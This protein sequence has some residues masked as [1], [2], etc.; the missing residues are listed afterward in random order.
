MPRRFNCN[1]IFRIQHFKEINMKWLRLFLIIFFFSSMSIA[2]K[3][4]SLSEALQ[5]VMGG[6]T[7]N[8][9]I[10][11][12]S[13]KGCISTIVMDTIIFGEM[14]MQTDWN[15]VIWNSKEFGVNDGGTRVV[16]LACKTPCAKYSG[17]AGELISEMM[18]SGL[19]ALMLGGDIER[20]VELPLGSS[21]PRVNRALAFIQ[22][23]C[24]GVTS[25][26]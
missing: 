25:R 1:L 17:P 20:L 11:K 9:L 13:F 22:S 10:K 16:R 7:G 2:V 6:D 4:Q 18:K 26:F 19:G 14:E 12:V 5:F 23:S 15:N 21:V 24:P 3:A 8:A